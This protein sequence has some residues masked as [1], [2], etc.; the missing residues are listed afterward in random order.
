MVWRLPVG[1]SKRRADPPD[2]SPN[3]YRVCPVYLLPMYPVC[4]HLNPLP[5]EREFF[6]EVPDRSRGRRRRVSGVTDVVV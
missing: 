2:P 6:E 5:R 3:G 4:T 1:I